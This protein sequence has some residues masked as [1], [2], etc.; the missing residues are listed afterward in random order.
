MKRR[1]L[2]AV[3][4]IAWMAGVAAVAFFAAILVDGE[5]LDRLIRDIRERPL[6][7]AEPIP[8]ESDLRSFLGRSLR[9]NHSAEVKRSA[10]N[11]PAL[12]SGDFRDLAD[13]AF[14]SKAWGESIRHDEI[15][16]GREYGFFD[17]T[18]NRP[19]YDVQGRE[20]FWNIH[21]F[22]RL[23][24]EGLP[25]RNKNATLIVPGAKADFGAMLD[26]RPADFMN[27]IAIRLMRLG[28]DVWI[29]AP[30]ESL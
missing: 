17:S 23:F 19:V 14:G 22:L 11:G 28:S 24:D 18:I 9:D 6:F 5:P 10:P 21:G 25:D 4:G 20:F 30:F 12:D 27:Q 13:A 2:A 3:A 15:S 16:V 7:L 29:V 26:R 8:F 1:A